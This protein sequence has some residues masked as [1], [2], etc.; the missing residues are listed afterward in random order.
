ML[1]ADGHAPDYLGTVD[2]DPASPTYSQV[3][4]RLPM[5]YK[6]DELHHS[7]WNA[8]SSCHSDGSKSRSLLVLPALGSGR[9]Y[10][11]LLKSSHAARLCPQTHDIKAPYPE[12]LKVLGHQKGKDM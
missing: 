3:I 7:G 8:C 10:G 12:M 2:V 1:H 5:P 9:V 11:A 6:G 4:H